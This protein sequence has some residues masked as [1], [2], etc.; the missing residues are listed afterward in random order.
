MSEAIHADRQRKR[1]V[2]LIEVAPPVARTSAPLTVGSAIDPAEQ[3]ADRVA[4]EVLARLR[5]EREADGQD[6]QRVAVAGGPVI[7]A[8]GGPLPPAVAEQ[9]ESMRGRGEPLPP[10]VRTRMEAAFNTDLSQVRVHADPQAAALSNSM[11]AVAFTRG[12]DIFFAAGEYAPDTPRGERTLAH[13]LAH[14]QQQAGIRRVHRLWNLKATSVPWHK[15]HSTRTLKSRNVWFIKDD[16]NDEIVVKIENQPIGLGDIVGSLQKKITNIKSVEQRKLGPSDRGQLQALIEESTA[17]QE[18]SWVARGR[19]MND[20]SNGN[21]ATAAEFAQIAE[22]DAVS[23]LQSN[24]VNVMAMTL[25]SGMKAEDWAAQA[26]G[27]TA[28]DT[29]LRAVL[30]APGHCRVLGQMTAVDLLLDNDDRAYAGNLGNWFYT[31]Q[32]PDLRSAMTLIDQVAPGMATFV[33]TR[34]WNNKDNMRSSNLNQTAAYTIRQIEGGMKRAGDVGVTAWL[35]TSVD[36]KTRRERFTAEFEVGLRL[37]RLRIIDIFTATRYDL[38]SKKERATKKQIKTAAMSATALD[39][40]DPRYGGAGKAAPNY[41]AE[42][43][44]RAT[45]MKSN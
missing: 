31:D 42:I 40:D 3:E 6:V 17:V 34:D 1:E 32:E 8:E 30:E 45:W 13:E 5:P 20:L 29:Q 22:D 11:A 4:E 25:A 18:P 37:A 7:G 14:I 2:K 24:A 36:G 19:E 26:R 12:S 44:R 43:K 33:A 35:D 38:F 23:Q 39:Q 41:Y 27:G 16:A 9:I 10:D 21:A 28:G 15:G